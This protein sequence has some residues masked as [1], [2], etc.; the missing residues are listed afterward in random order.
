MN[1]RRLIAVAVLTVSLAAPA[2]ADL[3]DAKEML[4][5]GDGKAAIEELEALAFGGDP[6]AMVLLGDM[7]H[8]GNGVTANFSLAWSWYHRAARQNDAV[9]Q[10]KLGRMMSRGE[11][12][13]RNAV[14]AL[15]LFEQAAKS[16]HEQAQL[17]AGLTYLN[18]TR[19]TRKSINKALRYLTAAAAQGNAEAELALEELHEQGT[20]L[21]AQT[22]RDEP[23][24]RSSEP[25]IDKMDEPGRIRAS[26]VTWLDAINSSFDGSSMVDRPEVN[27]QEV[28]GVFEVQIPDLVLTPNPG[29][30]I[31]FGLVELTLTPIGEAPV[32]SAEDWMAT[33]RY[34][35]DMRPPTR[36]EIHS[37]F[38]IHTVTYD[39]SD[40]SGVW[41]PA[42]YN[43]VEMTA[44]LRNLE[45]TDPS[46]LVLVR[47]EHANW[48][49][50]IQE[51]EPGIWSGPY[52][53]EVANVTVTPPEGGTVTLA[54][55]STETILNGVRV[56]AYGRIVNQ[57]NTDPEAFIN[58]LVDPADGNAMIDEMI[59]LVASS[60]FDFTIEDLVYVDAEGNQAFALATLGF[61]GS[62]SHDG[63][64]NAKMSISYEHAGLSVPLEGPEAAVVPRST[65]FRLDV[66][67]IPLESLARGLVELMG[68]A[69]VEMANADPNATMSDDFSEA[70]LQARLMDIVSAASTGMTI[71]LSMESD[72]SALGLT[73]GVE[74]SAEALF[75]L[76]GAFDLTVSDLDGV[77]A[78][79]D[80]DPMLGAYKEVFAAFA[81]TAVQASGTNGTGTSTFAIVIQPDGSLL[82]NGENAIA[83][84]TTAMTPDQQGQ[85]ELGQEN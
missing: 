13:P 47:A 31:R 48:V 8:E 42:L 53:M 50:D 81:A 79:I 61:G 84:A 57:L 2:L 63:A 40:I 12:A 22:P 52:R 3:N 27:V 59:A 73:G 82:V 65:Q 70:E 20:I 1:S 10:Y 19:Q 54:R 75:G 11:G 44:E 36:I 69:M 4:R 5:L 23:E 71:D 41:L 18:G 21:A 37:G 74:A 83:I 7:H 62:G 43:F 16:G 64:D 26:I 14:E 85:E 66:D 51:T 24:Q 39:A 72:L 78:M 32:E 60:E 67:R 55:V 68:Q 17:E 33:R 58:A 35:L 77:L 6:E 28:G 80:Q 38:E 25:A 45:L 34:R 76:T 15:S 49:S 29:D 30:S 56:E 9:A 46:G